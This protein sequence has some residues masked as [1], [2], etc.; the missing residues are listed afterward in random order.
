MNSVTDKKKVSGLASLSFVFS[1]VGFFVPFAGSLIGVILGEI[2]LRGLNRDIKIQGYGLAKMGV[3][4]G[5]FG[6]LAWSVIAFSMV[7]FR[8]LH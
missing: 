8:G 6:L 2:A 5:Y 4:F 3:N 7:Y 1:T